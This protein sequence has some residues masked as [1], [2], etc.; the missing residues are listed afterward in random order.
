MIQYSYMNNHDH[1]P[2]VRI[3]KSLEV[4]GEDMLKVQCHACGSEL[5]VVEEKSETLETRAMVVKPCEHCCDQA[6]LLGRTQ[7]IEEL[8]AGCQDFEEGK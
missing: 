8:E 6:A 7:L 4:K 3:F 1:S 5:E 2:L